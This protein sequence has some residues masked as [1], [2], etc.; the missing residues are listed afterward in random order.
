MAT[1]AAATAKLLEPEFEGVREELEG[2]PHA[3]I[4]VVHVGVPV[5]ELTRPLD[6]FGFLVPKRESSKILGAIWSS[7]IFPHRAPEGHALLTVFM[8]GRSHPE[9]ADLPTEH[10]RKRALDGLFETMGGGFSP[11]LLRARVMRNCIPQYT[12]GHL[13]RVERVRSQTSARGGIVLCGSYLDGISIPKCI[14]SGQN[15]VRA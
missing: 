15:A 5:R 14:E 4:A 1:P 13:Q 9:V 2:I 7:A 10:L 8:G 12:R 3:S 11:T 6:G